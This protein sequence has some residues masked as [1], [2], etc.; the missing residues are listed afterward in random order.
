MNQGGRSILNDR[1]SILISHQ[2]PES[3]QVQEK[4]DKK[5]I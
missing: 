5:G 3:F 1:R 2:T 4:I